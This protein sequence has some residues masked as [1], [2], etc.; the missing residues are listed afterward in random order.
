MILKDLLLSTFFV[1]V[2][3]L[4]LKCILL[5]QNDII[6]YILSVVFGL[7]FIF[8]VSMSFFMSKLKLKIDLLNSKISKLTQFDEITD[9]YK[10]GYFFEVVQK[11]FDISKRKNM[12]VS[13]MI[14]DI[15]DFK[16]IN[17]KYGHKLSDK[18]LSEVAQKLKTQIRGMDI[19][20]RFGGDEFAI[21]S[22]SNK[23]EF[24]KLADRI[25]KVL[26]EVALDN[27][28]ICISTSIGIAEL[29]KGDSLSDLIKRA[30][31]ALILAKQKGGNRVD[32]LEHFLL[33][34]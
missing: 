4:F 17:K 6:P 21:L 1:V 23:E 32:Y 34:E 30:E 9:V 11:Y 12:P 28:K 22:F 13:L 33:F 8:S 27:Q 16:D 5:V 31:E 20:G 15:D 7:I 29:Q 14:I 19:L 10:R 26:N 3:F 25:N 24:L 2:L 18:I